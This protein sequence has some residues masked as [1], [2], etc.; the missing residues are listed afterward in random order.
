MLERLASGEEEEATWPFA[1]WVAAAQAMSSYANWVEV[2]VIDLSD[3]EPQLD[4]ETLET[5]GTKRDDVNA[6]TAGNATEIARNAMDRKRS[7]QSI[8][9]TE[10]SAKRHC[11]MIQ[12]VRNT[13]TPIFCEANQDFLAHLRENGF[14]IL[15]GVLGDASHAFREEF[16]KAM[17]SVVP[18]LDIAKE[19]TWN[20]PKGFRGIVTSY[21]LPHADFAWMIRAHPRIRQAFAS[22]FGTEDLV[23]SLDAVI[24]QAQNSKSKLPGWLHKDQHPNHKGLSVQA[25]YT[26]FGS[27]PHDAG[28]C[29][30]PGSHQ[31]TF[32]WEWK[33][34]G[35]HLRAPEDADLKPLK[36]NVP[37]DSVVFFNSRLVHASVSGMGRVPHGQPA[38][39]GVCVAYAPITRRSEQTR[40][41]K[42]KAYLQGKCSS[43][44]PCDNFSLKPPLKSFQILKGAVTLPPPRPLKE[45]LALL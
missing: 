3:E 1:F 4:G 15:K 28:T 44:W 29:V 38:R 25:V 27:G 36:P 45:R 10:A 21:G 23:V 30:V 19:D 34:K 9:P 43:H 13:A 11:E 41:K 16:W 35:D 24:A 20:F 40:R 18:G 37:P 26:H 31:V 32:P 22:I 42:E 2:P 17:T 5:T 12:T 33:A 39:L 6:R 14:A 7:L 8:E